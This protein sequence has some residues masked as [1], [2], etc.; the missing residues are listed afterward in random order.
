MGVKFPEVE[1]TKVDTVLWLYKLE[2]HY[3]QEEYNVVFS[4]KC[5]DV[6]DLASNVSEKK[7]IRI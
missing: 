5:H 3:L 7:Y 4:V 2:Y 1:L 6:Y